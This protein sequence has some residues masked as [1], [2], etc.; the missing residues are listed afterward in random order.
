MRCRQYLCA[1]GVA[2]AC[3]HVPR[4]SQASD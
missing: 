3:I 1:H 4:N 2:K